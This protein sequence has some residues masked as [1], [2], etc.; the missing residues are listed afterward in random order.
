MEFGLVLRQGVLRSSDV[1]FFGG[2]RNA[3]RNRRPRDL[4]MQEKVGR[5]RENLMK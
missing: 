3:D 2:D 5:G 4:H 1:V